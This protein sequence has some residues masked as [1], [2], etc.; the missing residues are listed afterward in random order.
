MCYHEEENMYSD[1]KQLDVKRPPF[2]FLVFNLN[3][4]TFSESK[5]RKMRT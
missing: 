1:Q 3:L 2:F 5:C 4:K